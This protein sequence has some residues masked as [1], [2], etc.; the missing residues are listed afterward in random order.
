MREINLTAKQIITLKKRHKLCSEQKECDRI[1]AIL[2][3]NK[4]WSASK[5][6]DALLVLEKSIK[7]YIDDYLDKDKLEI[8]SGGYQGHLTDEQTKPQINHLLK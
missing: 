6:A 8:Q 2:L 1:K 3:R 5:I 4:D 7:C